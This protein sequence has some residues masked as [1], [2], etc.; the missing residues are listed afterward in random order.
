MDGDAR[1]LVDQALERW[2]QAGEQGE[3]KQAAAAAAAELTAQAAELLRK[4][5]IR[6]PHH[7]NATLWLSIHAQMLLEL[8]TSGHVSLDQA[9]ISL[10]RALERQSAHPDPDVDADVLRNG[11]AAV[12][13]EHATRLLEQVADHAHES[14]ESS[15]DLR[16]SAVALLQEAVSVAPQHED[17]AW[18][19]K[20]LGI[21]L[22]RLAALETGDATFD[23][24]ADWLRRAL[25][26]HSH[27]PYPAIDA[28]QTALSLADMLGA[29]ATELMEQ[30]HL[31][32]EERGSLKSR[33]DL[34][35]AAAD[36]FQEALRVAPGHDDAV[37]SMMLLG[38]VLVEL[39]EFEEASYDEA[40]VWLRRALAGEPHPDVDRDDIV[41]SLAYALFSASFDRDSEV[42]D[43]PRLI[44]ALDGLPPT[45]EGSPAGVMVAYFRGFARL[46][47]CDWPA[48]GSSLT[49]EATR[50]RDLGRRLLGE[51]LPAM[52][53]DDHF[54]LPPA[55]WAYASASTDADEFDDAAAAITRARR[56]LTLDDDAYDL[57]MTE[58]ELLR[59]RYLE[60]DDPLDLDAF[61]T[62]VQP[63]AVEGRANLSVVRGLGE[64]LTYRGREAQEIADLEQA[65]RWL[66]GVLR[67]DASDPND[68]A[69]T[70]VLL[71]DAHEAWA[72]LDDSPHRLVTSADCFTAA[73]EQL[74]NGGTLET[75]AFA[76]AGLINVAQMRLERA[77]DE[78]SAVEAIENAQTALAAPRRLLGAEDLEPASRGSLAAVM[79]AL[80]WNLGFRVPNF[81]DLD[82]LSHLVELFDD[83]AGSVRKMPLEFETILVVVK[84]A[85]QLG[86]DCVNPTAAA[87]F[88]V[89][90][91][92]E[93]LPNTPHPELVVPQLVVGLF[94]KGTTR[95]DRAALEVVIAL[96]RQESDLVAPFIVKLAELV[97]LTMPGSGAAM[98][99]H[100]F[101]AERLLAEA[102]A[103]IAADPADLIMRHHMLPMLL[104]WQSLFSLSE[105][106]SEPRDTR[107]APLSGPLAG[108]DTI[109]EA[110][111]ALAA[112][113]AVWRDVDRRVAALASARRA[114]I[115]SR[116]PGRLDIS[117]AALIPFWLLHVA[118]T[119][120][121]A[122]LED[123]VVLVEEVLA[124]LEGPTDAF[125][126]LAAQLASAVHR[127]SPSGRDRARE[128]GLSALTGHAWEVLAQSGVEP[129]LMAARTAAGD[130]LRVA[131]WCAQDGDLEGM[132]RAIEAGRG[133]VLHAAVT[134]RTVTEQLIELGRVDLAREWDEA[135]G[136]DMLI[137]PG[138][139]GTGVDV[140]GDLRHRVLAALATGR[141]ADLLDPPGP[142]EVQE[143]LRAHGSDALI[144]LLPGQPTVGAEQDSPTGQPAA[145][146]AASPADP[147]TL[148][149]PARPGRLVIVPAKGPI[150]LITVPDLLCGPQSPLPAYA[151][152]Y[153][154]WHAAQGRRGRALRAAFERWQAALEELIDWAG[155]LA[156]DTGRTL[157]GTLLASATH[158]ATDPALPRLAL[159]PLGQLAMVPWHA[160]PTGRPTPTG[161]WDGDRAVAPDVLAV[162]AVISY[163][164]SVRL[165][166]RV[167]A[168]TAAPADG[169]VLVVGN[170][171]RDKDLRAVSVEAR[172]LRDAFYPE[173]TYLGWLPPGCVDGSQPSGEGTAAEVM[174]WLRAA[175]GRHRRVVHFGCHGVAEPDSPT[176]SRLELADGP[177]TISALL[178]AQ[179]IDALPVDRVFLA[180]CVTNVSGVDY[181]EAF[182]LA[183][184]FL[185]AG[186]RTAFGSQ[187][188]VPAGF[189]SQLMFMVHY[190]LEELSMSPAGALRQAQLWAL[191]PDRDTP[192]SMPTDLA[193]ARPSG[194]SFSDPVAWAGYVHLGV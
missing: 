35:R 164:P 17:V 185:A 147:V 108:M 36:R 97:L 140:H 40:A 4:A 20:L 12:L 175:R 73:L 113:V 190:F 1:M 24:A 127:L 7:P 53:D 131:E 120:D 119:G 78:A 55:L 34:R 130:A 59:R 52:A 58:A 83:L 133:L 136:A 43:L 114:L 70:W 158:W 38:V 75:A 137:V 167:I 125:W 27:R 106:V 172:A 10:R 170:P 87:D 26:E 74:A 61:I 135:G 173:A 65:V 138:V 92:L 174:E 47:E 86:R 157:I 110:S 163:V 13:G 149:S 111:N 45:S 154:A 124:S 141:T 64:M 112:A 2:A 44:T 187:W 29:Q 46:V 171:S 72:E 100:V 107:P 186:A 90:P 99:Q 142:R 32:D 121:L 178:A 91:L 162:H 103:Q 5:V 176:L 156:T 165:L 146:G 48:D 179:P 160:I 189:S 153:T 56:L 105:P 66:R 60:D 69:R 145:S 68:I 89:T 85:I 81:L 181:D 144:Y 161:A 9:A 22:G 155:R 41:G 79:L 116:Q 18:S 3:D 152:V 194:Y 150:E 82:W 126:A 33:T 143:A 94:L 132:V 177:L 62:L 95:H 21:T 76:H 28:D 54:L 122:D 184:T 129:G 63:Y 96:G 193:R 123:Y 109:T 151:E 139:E 77:M 159:A 115:A 31:R 118:E 98:A 134:T 84:S 42:Q 93:I 169:G 8:T 101:V 16:R 67:A 182:S 188:A 80:E 102:T 168:T 39:A 183:T 11:L 117:R 14:G 30:A 25:A 57:D 50:E 128:L 15:V 192:A 37:L 104:S 88:G 180:A 148:P 23:D 49:A 166:R 191:D 19:M 71:G 6:D 51:A